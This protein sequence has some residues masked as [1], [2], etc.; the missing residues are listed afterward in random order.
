[1]EKMQGY[2]SI[3]AA[4]VLWG[5]MGILATLSFAYGILPVTLIALRLAISFA[6]LSAILILFG[7]NPLRIQKT[8]TPFFIIFGIFAIA[9]QR[10][11]YFYAVSL[12]TATMAAILFYTYPVFVTFSALFFL[13]EKI[14]LRELTAI[15]L[16]F[17]GVAFVVRAY[18]TS[19]LSNNLLG[20][21]SGLGSS[22]LFVLYFIMTK[23]LRNKYTS[24]TLTLFGDGIGT[25]ALT[26]IITVSIPQI[27]RFPTQLWLLIFTIAWVPSLLAYLLYSY[28]LKY[29]KSSKGSVLSVLEPLSA[30]VLSSII[31]GERLE[32]L[33]ITGIALSLTGVVLLFQTGKTMT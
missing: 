22:L 27:T 14:S 21:F 2:A 4:S 12:T 20:I 11:S 32:N 24:W 9:L 18:D 17:I 33:Q 29:V 7:K 13:K 26:P 25:L 19:A 3:V 5:T 15:T 28:A 8:D 16:T 6:T 30:A 10:I 1:M 23:K 31:L